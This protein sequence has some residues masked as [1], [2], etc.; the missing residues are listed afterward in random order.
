MRSPKRR[1]RL[2]TF[3]LAWLY[4]FVLVLG[5]ITA[6]W[7]CWYTMYRL[8]HA[9]N[10]LEDRGV[11]VVGQ[12]DYRED[13][14]RD[15]IAVT[16]TYRG[17]TR[18][19]RV[20]DSVNQFRYSRAG[21]LEK[22]PVL[23]DPE[24]P[25]T[26][27]TVYDVRARTNTGLSF[28]PIFV[29]CALIFCVVG[30][31]K[32]IP[33]ARRYVDLMSPGAATWTPPIEAPPPRPREPLGEPDE[34][35][36]AWLAQGRRRRWAQAVAWVVVPSAIVVAL[37]GTGGGSADAGEDPTIS[38]PLARKLGYPARTVP[39]PP[40]LISTVNLDTAA[41]AAHCRVR[42]LPM[43][44]RHDIARIV[45]GKV[46]Y[47]SNPP[48][49]G[50]HS[51]AWARDG[52]YAGRRSPAPEQVVHALARG[53]IVVQYEPGTPPRAISRLQNLMLQPTFTWAADD[54]TDGAY[55]LLLE[56]TTGMRYAVAA[57]AWRELLGCPIFNDRVFD[58]VRAFRTANTLRGPENARKVG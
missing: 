58:A 37:T 25:D 43:E 36:A 56:N 38:S 21:T 30:L 54:V 47:R 46:H 40:K 32:E 24:D 29:I 17:R 53:R 8:P 39:A 6:I 5:L 14:D 16:F 52:N 50:D 42:R 49:S 1:S 48:T 11:R 22:V 31:V 51:A 2:G 45:K 10:T 23:V 34:R 27:F 35:Q 13:G 57:T 20:F 33:A 7:G 55:A 3:V 19:E 44:G 15:Y 41:K 9:Y 26:A 18:E 12:P 4:P 28:F